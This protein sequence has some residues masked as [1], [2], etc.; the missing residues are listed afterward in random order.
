MAYNANRNLGINSTQQA[1]SM[2]KL[3]SGLRINRAG[4]DA[5]GLAISEKMRSQIRGLEQASRNAQDG[6][7]LIQTAEGALGE[8]QEMLQ[9]A[10]ELAVQ[11]LN[12]TYTES[13]REK[14]DLEVQQLLEEIDGIA[15]KTEF[16]DLKLLSG[17]VDEEAEAMDPYENYDVDSM[18]ADQLA[19]SI[20]AAEKE[21]TILLG[22]DENGT[23]VTDL[24]Q[25][26][27]E[28][29]M[30][31]G[32]IGT[33]SDNQEFTL[34]SFDTLSLKDKLAAIDAAY[35]ND[36]GTIVTTGM[37]AYA[38]LDASTITSIESIE[39]ILQAERMEYDSLTSDTSYDQKTLEISTIQNQ[40]Y[41][42]LLDRAQTEYDAYVNA[43]GTAEM[44]EIEAGTYAAIDIINCLDEI[45]KNA[46]GIFPSDGYDNGKFYE[47]MS[48]QEKL[49]YYDKWKNIAEVD[50]DGALPAGATIDDVEGTGT[51][52]ATDTSAY[53]SNFESTY[54]SLASTILEKEEEIETLITERDELFMSDY[55][56]NSSINSLE[57]SINDLIKLGM[58]SEDP[59][60]AAAWKEISSILT[61][62][63][64]D[65]NDEFPDDLFCENTGKHFNEMSLEEKMNF[66]DTYK[67][68]ADPSYTAMDGANAYM[69]ISG[70]NPN[71]FN[72]A[73]FNPA[74]D[75]VYSQENA[76]ALASYAE[77][78]LEAIFD[79]RYSE[80]TDS[81]TDVLSDVS[82]ILE[83]VDELD[84]DTDEYK[85]AL[86]AIIGWNGDLDAD[87]TVDVL[88]FEERMQL[89]G[90]C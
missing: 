33:S 73:D 11:A 37:D 40:I 83:A 74:T 46:D 24:I 12:D 88:T 80:E 41:S 13:D 50:S 34:T 62:V 5:A 76:D 60:T 17:I 29:I 90:S 9:R 42:A 28:E 25:T 43:G 52:A 21:I 72:P 20:A 82:A 27:M 45:E 22:K 84:T 71:S 47:D 56:V 44:S 7:S 66:Y 79:S 58:A 87:S 23:N 69:A 85:A 81:L 3:S 67:S 54:G 61:K 55:N 26:A 59:A 48:I 39:T 4:D 86:K 1:S 8:T 16:N 89:P 32:Y 38:T 75:T 30:E 14:L 51:G 64:N 10:R 19:E 68:I 65:Y 63:E 6:I 49:E 31:N 15:D 70:V 78:E 57:N 35:S 36:A 2:E 53:W 77:S 18:R